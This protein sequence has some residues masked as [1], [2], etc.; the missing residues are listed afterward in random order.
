VDLTKH[1][2]ARSFEVGSSAGMAVDLSLPPREAAPIDASI[3][4]VDDDP[5][6]LEA[7]TRINLTTNDF[8]ADATPPWLDA[9]ARMPGEGG[10]ARSSRP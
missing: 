5:A 2:M 6:A 4:E 7:A 9:L 3:R 1:L 10:S 8:P